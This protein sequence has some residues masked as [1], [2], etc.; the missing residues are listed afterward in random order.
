MDTRFGTWIVG[1]MY[2]S[3][4]LMTVPRELRVRFIGNAGGKI[5]GQWHRTNRR[6]NI[7]YGN[8]NENNELVTGI[9]VHKTIISAVKRVQFVSERMSYI[10]LS[11]RWRHVIVLNDH[12]PTEN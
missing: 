5:W 11:G 10:I 8:G 2:R 9:F 3:G 4:S 1:S 7:F 12:V 6:I